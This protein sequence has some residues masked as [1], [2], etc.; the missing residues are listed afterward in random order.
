MRDVLLWLV[1]AIDLTMIG[2]IAY[3]LIPKVD[4]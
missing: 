2:L 1:I 4:R 3:Y